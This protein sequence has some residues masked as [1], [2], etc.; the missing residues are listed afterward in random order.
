MSFNIGTDSNKLLFPN[1]ISDPDRKGKRV[2]NNPSVASDKSPSLDS[3]FSNSSYP[4]S[5]RLSHLPPLKS[6]NEEEDDQSSLQSPRSILPHRLSNARIRES[7][8]FLDS[9]AL[10]PFQGVPYV[11]EIPRKS[12]KRE[13]FSLRRYQRNSQTESSLSLVKPGNVSAIVHDIEMSEPWRYVAN[14]HL[15]FEDRLWTMLLSLFSNL[16]VSK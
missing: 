6:D 15:V 7:L 14:I 8:E 4:S 5:M 11:P 16:Q 1:A 10:N 13:T 3:E 12:S 2:S 9:S